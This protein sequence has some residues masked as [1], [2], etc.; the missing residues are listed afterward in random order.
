[1]LIACINIRFL[2]EV[3]MKGFASI[4]TA[5]MIVFLFSAKAPAQEK[6]PDVIAYERLVLMLDENQDEAFGSN[7]EKTVNNMVRKYQEFMNRFPS[8]ALVPQIYIRIAEMY[9]TINRNDVGES[10]YQHYASLAWAYLS[11]AIT[12]Y[13]DT[14]HYSYLG[15]EKFGYVGDTVGSVALYMRAIFFSKTRAKDLELLRK[16][17]PDTPSAKK[18]FHELAASKT[19]KRVFIVAIITA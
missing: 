2:G 7:W 15:G 1:M 6:P 12:S 19:L 4:F 11:A 18:A 3:F 14:P 13:S 5:F 17:F 10:A 8:S 9:L 16:K